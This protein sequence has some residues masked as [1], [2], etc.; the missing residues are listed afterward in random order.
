MPNL[1]TD[2]QR[3][4]FVV[5]QGMQTSQKQ[6]DGHP[7]WKMKVVSIHVDKDGT[8][9]IVGAWFYSPSDLKELKL[10]QGYATSF[11]IASVSLTLQQGQGPH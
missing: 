11:V 4:V 9:W 7:Y 8:Y 1:T 3:S 5:H 10:S 6:P 2:T